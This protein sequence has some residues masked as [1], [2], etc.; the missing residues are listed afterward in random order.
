LAVYTIAARAARVKED[1]MTA[2]LLIVLGQDVLQWLHDTS[3]TNGKSSAIDLSRIFNLSQT[4]RR[5]H[6][7]S[8]P[9]CARA[10]RPSARSSGDSKQ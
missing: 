9:S 10:T 6:G 7:T 8:I 2:Y 3:S 1:V 4:N 5:N